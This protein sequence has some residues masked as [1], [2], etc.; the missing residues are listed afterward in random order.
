MLQEPPSSNGCHF[1]I[2]VF[3]VWTIMKSLHVLNVG[4][5]YTYFTQTSGMN[6]DV[7]LHTS[8]DIPE[9][10]IFLIF[11]LE[12][13][14]EC[15]PCL[16]CLLQTTNIA[17]LVTSYEWS[18]SSDMNT[19]YQPEHESGLWRWHLCATTMII[20]CCT[21]PSFGIDTDDA[22]CSGSTSLPRTTFNNRSVAR[23]YT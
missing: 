9:Y 5:H 3:K 6:I 1:V 4:T 22:N 15:P 16:S 2:F 17:L 13:P 18:T 14:S 19:R 12:V 8:E 11:M 7:I 10:T 23:L 20:K 21:C